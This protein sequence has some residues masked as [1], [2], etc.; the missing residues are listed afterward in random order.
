MQIDYIQ[1]SRKGSPELIFALSVTSR[2]SNEKRK[3]T[4][5]IAAGYGWLSPAFDQICLIR[6][7]LFPRCHPQIRTI[8]SRSCGTC[9]DETLLQPNAEGEFMQ[10]ADEKFHRNDPEIT[11]AFK[12]CKVWQSQ[13]PGAPAEHSQK[14]SR[15]KVWNKRGLT[16]FGGFLPVPSG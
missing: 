14:P 6:S 15:K 16:A 8:S 10:N 11:L 4:Y 13:S 9:R 12:V 7:S 1:A 2:E 3:S 5:C